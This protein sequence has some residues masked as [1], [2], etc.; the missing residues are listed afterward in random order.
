MNE[1]RDCFAIAVAIAQAE[2]LATSGG[3]QTAER[4]IHSRADT[5][6]LAVCL[7]GTTCPHDVA[8]HCCGHVLSTHYPV[9]LVPMNSD[10]WIN[11]NKGDEAV[12]TWE[13]VQLLLMHEF[14][15][16]EL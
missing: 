6:S 3:R 10:W 8:D 13:M 9:C 2:A 1:Q 7:E 12:P 15:E 5:S 4:L 16:A 14:A 11:F